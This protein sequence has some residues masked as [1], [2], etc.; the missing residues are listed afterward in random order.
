MHPK[1]PHPETLAL[2]AGYSVEP[3]TFARAVPIYQ[4][5][6]FT[7]KN[8][9]HAA[10]VFALKTPGNIYSRITNPTN[11]V[12]EER[13]AAME[14]GLASLALAS[15]QSATLVTMLTLAKAGD[16]ILSS[17]SL[18]GGT[19]NL[20]TRTLPRLGIQCRLVETA[21]PEAVEKAIS[22]NT[23]ALFVEMLGNPK[24]DVAHLEALSEITHK[25]GIPLIVDNTCA[26]T[27]LVRPIQYGANLVI[28]SATKF[29]GGHGQALGGVVVDA[30]NF[31]WDNGRFPEFVQPNPNY[32][33]LKLVEA[34]GPAAFIAKARVEVL[35]DLGP[36]LSPF[37]AHAFIN[38]LETLFL[39]MQRHSANA[40]TVARFLKSAPQVAWVRYP[41]LED[42]AFHALAK[43]YLRG[44]FGALVCF[45]LKGGREAGQK[46]VD[47][48]QLFS[49]VA[50]IGDTRSLVV[51]PAS[52]THQQLEE[53]EQ[54][55]TGVTPELVR[56]SVGLEHPEDILE[57]LAQ[58]LHG[59]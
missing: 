12:F 21:Q 26:T 52:T 22:P 19:H 3:T 33:G 34:F 55:I 23:R 37:H 7:F 28:H 44:G 56:L 6:A 1:K 25:A 47:K 39:R 8:T 20:L 41:G 10:E 49:L 51:H 45:G 59:L 15:G 42:D 24:L 38:G 46:L 57:D 31:P 35:R 5:T 50:N 14:G 16:E 43:H 54:K 53:E 2:H 13:L 17:T 29:I 11:A 18:Y 9:Q 48:L 40:L 4:S 58:A 32:H 36:A 30:G 27:A